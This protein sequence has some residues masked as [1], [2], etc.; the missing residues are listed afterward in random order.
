MTRVIL[1]LSILVMTGWAAN[2]PSSTLEIIERITVSNQFARI[3]EGPFKCDSDSS[4]FVSPYEGGAFSR[5]LVKIE[6]K[7]RKV[8][9]FPTSLPP[10]LEKAVTVDFAIGRNNEVYFLL[11]LPDGHRILSVDSDGKAGSHNK[12]ETKHLAPSHF[13][14]FDT[15]DFL[16]AGRMLEEGQM[17]RPFIH[18][19]N[20]RG[21]FLRAV[22]AEGDVTPK[23]PELKQLPKEEGFSAYDLAMAS[24]AEK[25]DDGNV[26][27]AR[28]TQH[29]PIFVI[30]PAGKV[31]RTLKFAP[32]NKKAQFTSFKVASGRIVLQFVENDPKGIGPGVQTLV[33]LDSQN[34]KELL[35]YSDKNP[36]IGLAFACYKPH[37]DEFVFVGA[38]QDGKMQLVRAGAAR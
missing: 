26:Y 13:L 23:S 29:G 19:I 21:H 31:L 9:K 3:L 1:L 14:V 17:G 27:L 4:V 30:S 12:L 28:S 7:G 8:T 22:R 33:V 15:G 34:G 32:P 38:N 24:M 11:A 16:I 6:D 35:R 25:G 37:P 20:D 5:N 36:E 2:P 10:G 18:V